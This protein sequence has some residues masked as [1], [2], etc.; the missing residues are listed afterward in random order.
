MELGHNMSAAFPGRK[1]EADERKSR[2]PMKEMTKWILRV[3]QGVQE[4]RWSYRA[5]I[6]RPNAPKR[7]GKGA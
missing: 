3:N 4:S 1:P 5:V 2:E 7:G 6:L